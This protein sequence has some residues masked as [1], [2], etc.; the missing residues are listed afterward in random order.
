MLAEIDSGNMF[1]P[2]LKICRDHQKA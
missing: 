2:K 1:P